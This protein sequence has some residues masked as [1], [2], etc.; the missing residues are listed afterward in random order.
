MRKEEKVKNKVEFL[1][2]GGLSVLGLIGTLFFLKILIWGLP[3][4]TPYPA[5][6]FFLFTLF[7]FFTYLG[8]HKILK[9][10]K[11]IGITYWDVIA[12]NAAILSTLIWYSYTRIE[13]G[14][15]FSYVYAFLTFLSLVC[16]LGYL[17]VEEFIQVWLKTFAVY[18]FL[19]ATFYYFFCPFWISS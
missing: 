6:P 17:F 2:L 18:L 14:T 5:N 10:K 19:A 9:S 8:I 7:A 4:M 16:W 15:F 1:L 12:I 11:R 13:P 3:H